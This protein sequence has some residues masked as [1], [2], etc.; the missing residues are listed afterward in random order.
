M[1][2]NIH[3]PDKELGFGDKQRW[4]ATPSGYITART[5]KPKY[6]GKLHSGMLGASPVSEIPMAGCLISWQYLAPD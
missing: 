3:C 4:T 6:S 1:L 5:Y 2:E